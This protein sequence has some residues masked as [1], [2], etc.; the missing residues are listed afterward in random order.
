MANILLQPLNESVE[1]EKDSR[2]LDALLAKDCPVMMACG[3]QAICATCHCYVEEGAENLNP[4][5][6]REKRTL[7]LITGATSKSRLSCQTRITGTGDVTVLLPEGL[8]IESA[9]DL[10]EL[11][12]QRTKAPIRHPADGSIL[13][14]RGKIITRSRIME[15]QGTD[16]SLLSLEEDDS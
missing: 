9:D 14:A 4:I 11:I 5:S 10:E 3:G 16:L 6:D 15:L 7:A 8:Y 12:G 2:L 1:A 13:I